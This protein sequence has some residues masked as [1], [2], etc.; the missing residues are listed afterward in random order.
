MDS[1]PPNP[2]ASPQTTAEPLSAKQQRPSLWLLWVWVILAVSASL[3]VS[4]ADPISI[5]LALAFGLLAFG[6]GAV[7]AASLPRAVRLVPLIAWLIGA[8]ALTTIWGGMGGTMV[9]IG[10]YGLGSI[11]LGWCASARLSEGRT[12]IVL[13][14]CA[15][16]V[17]G[18]ILG[19]LGTIAGAITGALLARGTLP[20]HR[21]T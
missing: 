19:P 10:I 4:P 21:L 18:S 15:G 7:Q 20:R 17:F 13:A 6:V 9:G 1:S 2:Y 11:G 16:Y 14:F 8:G 12:R 3:I 5:W